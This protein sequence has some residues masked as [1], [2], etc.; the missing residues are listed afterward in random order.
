MVQ[1]GN[2]DRV[3]LVEDRGKETGAVLSSD[4]LTRDRDTLF[5]LQGALGYDLV[6]HL[7]VAENNV[8]VEARLTTRI[9]N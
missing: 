6:Q 5:P 1:P 4:V 2:L 7:F 8:V 9:S 3:R